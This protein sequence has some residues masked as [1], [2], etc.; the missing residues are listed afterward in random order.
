MAH[1]DEIVG[2]RVPHPSGGVVEQC[3]V[4][5]D[6]HRQR[7]WSGEGEVGAVRAGKTLSPSTVAETEGGGRP[8]LLRG[9]AIT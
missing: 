6:P 9:A 5:A 3:L 8:R 1:H 7:W 2:A 4:G